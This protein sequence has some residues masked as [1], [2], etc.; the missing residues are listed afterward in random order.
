MLEGLSASA[1][2]QRAESVASPRRHLSIWKAGDNK[3]RPAACLGDSCERSLVE[4]DLACGV[5]ELE[6]LDRRLYRRASGCLLYPDRLLRGVP[7]H[8]DQART[9][10]FRDGK[11]WLKPH[12]HQGEVFQHRFEGGRKRCMDL[13]ISVQQCQRLGRKGGR[14]DRSPGL[15]DRAMCAGRERAELDLG[16]GA[17]GDWMRQPGEAA[18]VTIS[19][20]QPHYIAG[21]GRI[22]AGRQDWQRL[23]VRISKLVVNSVE[24]QQVL[25]CWLRPDPEFPGAVEHRH[26]QVP[27]GE[28]QSLRPARNPLRRIARL[29]EPRTPCG[30]SQR[31]STSRR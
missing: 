3:D 27:G 31:M 4:G 1:A 18:L 13:G 20:V 11:R 14:P 26:P 25:G 7:P 8:D 23:A 19:E 15:L 22:K 10:L 28:G 29:N 9:P 5:V 12:R 16:P 6:E 21:K 24:I 2:C 17:P 30:T